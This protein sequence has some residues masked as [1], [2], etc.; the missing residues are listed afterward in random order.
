MKTR[1][2]NSP[3]RTPLDRRRI[4]RTA[5]AVI[6]EKGIDHLTMRGIGAALDVEAM[7]LYHHFKN[8]AELLDG[9]KDFLLDELASRIGTAG[10]PVE[11]IEAT[12]QHLRQMAL[13]HPDII[14]ALGASRF[15]T[16]RSMTFFEELIG[17]FYAAGL[18]TEQSARYYGLLSQYTLGCGL[19]TVGART[20][21]A[22]PPLDPET[23]A[24]FPRRGKILPY[25]APDHREANYRFG[26]GLI[27]NAMRA[28]S[29][30]A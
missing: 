6:D 2:S 27:L 28:E 13:E 17:L 16:V 25:T 30:A 5:L 10:T 22:L 20:Q 15:R 3:P 23:A 26:I 8:K 18:D 9:V 21:D 11:R 7:A 19:Y 4:V 1:D 14:P 12:F 24:M 29:N